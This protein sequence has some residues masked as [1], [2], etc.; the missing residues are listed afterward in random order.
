MGLMPYKIVGWVACY[1]IKEKK[2]NSI[3]CAY[4]TAADHE[5]QEAHY[6][7]TSEYMSWPLKKT[8]SMMWF[9]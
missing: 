1:R 4:I 2:L 5:L 3:D 6:I 9:F 7:S 8:V